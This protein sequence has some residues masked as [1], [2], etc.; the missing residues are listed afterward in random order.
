MSSLFERNRLL[1]AHGRT[2]QLMLR[3]ARYGRL[4]WWLFAITGMGCVVLSGVFLW[5][6]RPVLV[7]DRHGHVV[8]QICWR[9]V[10]VSDRAVIRDSIAFASSFLSMNSGTVFTD[11]AHALNLMTPALRGRIMARLKRTG[12][13]GRV[14]DA[15]TVSWVDIAG[16]ANRPRLL[17]RTAKSAVV[18]LLGT[19]AVVGDGQRRNLPFRLLLNLRLVAMDSEH[20]LGIEVSQVVQK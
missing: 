2:G 9:H 6:P 11:Y 14:R 12:Y 1:D 5:A 3:V 16:G 15:H 18:R 8:G 4:G 13:L 17:R 7:V 10:T 20:R 19:I